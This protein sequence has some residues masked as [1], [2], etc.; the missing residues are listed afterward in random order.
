M[1]RQKFRL[2]LLF[3]AVCVTY[4]GFLGAKIA[5][6]KS[7][8]AVNL[9]LRDMTGKRSS[10]RELRGKI[11]VLN[12]WATWCGPCKTEMPMLVQADEQYKKRGV[13]FLGASLDD[14]KSE[15]NI[16]AFV[17]RYHVPYSILTG[18]TADDLARLKMGIAV[19]ATAFID[20]KGRIRFRI[21]GQM[22]P[23]ELQGRID[24]LLRE[25]SDAGSGNAG[26]DDAGTAPP[27]LVT[28]L[29]EK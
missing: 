8:R 18:A 11:V 24:W 10:L 15:K 3:I 17:D 6:E 25:S 20:A 26:K 4:T 1:F 13:E 23:R 22:R 7:P 28:H 16:P 2:L 9:S 19:P 29:D 14:S 21:L 12:F 5:A 27:A